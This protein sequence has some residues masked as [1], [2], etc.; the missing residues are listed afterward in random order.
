MTTKPTCDLQEAADLLKVHPKTVQDLIRD[1]VL[2]A[3]KVGRSWVMMTKDVLAH[4]ENTIVRQ[5]AE[6]MRKPVTKA[7]PQ[8]RR[9][10]A[11]A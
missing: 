5:T 3:A 8:A 6:R 10:V 7:S 2:P 9:Q 11:T 1:G 4:L